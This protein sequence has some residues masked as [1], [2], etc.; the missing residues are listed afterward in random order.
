MF[1][2]TFVMRSIWPI[3]VASVLTISSC[4]AARAQEGAFPNTMSDDLQFHS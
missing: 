1:G 2:R 4:R 3:I